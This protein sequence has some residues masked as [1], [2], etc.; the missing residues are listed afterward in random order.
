MYPQ[1]LVRVCVVVNV[2]MDMV[3]VSF[4]MLK[5]HKNMVNVSSCVLSVPGH[6]KGAPIYGNLDMVNVPM[7]WYILPTT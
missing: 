6:G 4:G 5:V 3:Y 2:P 1:G 7:T